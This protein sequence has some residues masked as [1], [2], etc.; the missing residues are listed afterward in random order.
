M[1]GIAFENCVDPDQM[2]S[3]KAI[4]SGTTLFVIQFVNLYE[5]T[6]MSYLIG[7]QSEMGVANLIYSSG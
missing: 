4:W 7:W 5:K 1:M 3:G 2:A 6:T